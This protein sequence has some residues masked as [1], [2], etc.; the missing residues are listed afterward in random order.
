[1]PGLSVSA[2]DDRPGDAVDPLPQPGPRRRS[3]RSPT[4]TSAASSSLC[5]GLDGMALAIELAAARLPSLG[6]DGLESGLADRLD[7]SSPAAPARRPAPLAALGPGL[8]LRAA[9]RRRPRAAAPRLG[10][11]RPVR[12]GLG[13]RRTGRL[14]TRSTPTACRRCWPGSP[15]RASWSPPRRPGGTRYRALETIRQ[16]GAA[17][18]EDAGET[19]EAPRPPSGLDPDRAQ[20][21]APAGDRRPRGR[22]LA[23]GLRRDLDR[24]PAG[25]APGALRAPSS[26]TRRTGVAAARRAELRPRP[27]RVSPSAATSSP[28]S[29]RPTTTPARSPCAWPPAR[30]RPG[31]SATR[32][33]A[34][35]TLAAEAALRAGDRTGGRL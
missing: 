13:R 5:R 18:V 20:A 23:S 15:T 7:C 11:R 30:P 14:G 17:L 34:C 16:Y 24:D 21:A 29:S 35:G 33:C 1:M 27:A 28:P 25:A 22:R 19:A 6:L 32:R 31:S 26:A 3:R 10:L 4:T 2:V 9:R 12:R 8:E